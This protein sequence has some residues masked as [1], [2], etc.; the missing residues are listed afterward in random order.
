MLLNFE[1]DFGRKIDLLVSAVRETIK[2]GCLRAF[3]FLLSTCFRRVRRDCPDLGISEFSHSLVRK[4]MADIPVRLP[5]LC[6]SQA[7][8]AVLLVEKRYPSRSYDQRG[9]LFLPVLDIRSSL[10]ASRNGTDAALRLVV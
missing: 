9:G 1:M 5:P 6:P 2:S 7:N 8:L 4:G 3:G 10:L